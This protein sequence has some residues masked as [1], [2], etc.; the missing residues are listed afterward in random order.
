M[1]DSRQYD[2]WAQQIA[3]GDWVGTQ[4]FYQAPLYPYCLAVL[5]TL[6]GHDLGF[7][8]LVQAALGAASC[9]LLGLAGRRF[10]SDRAGVIAA[11]LLAVYPPAFFFD[12]LIQKSSLDIFLVTLMLALLGEF[13]ARRDRK[14]LAVLGVATA[15]FVLNRENA[16]DLVPCPGEVVFDLL[17]GQPLDPQNVRATQTEVILDAKNDIILQ[18]ENIHGVLGGTAGTGVVEGRERLP[19]EGEYLSPGCLD[20]PVRARILA[21]RASIHLRRRRGAQVEQRIGILEPLVNRIGSSGNRHG[22]GGFRRPTGRNFI[23]QDT[24]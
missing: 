12:G 21:P 13:G 4:I 8:R 10:F 7:E 23:F 5:F 6:A 3:N 24:L 1:G 14:W 20:R 15:A 19:A 9:A 18:T 17:A 16:A 2:A 11:L 22:L